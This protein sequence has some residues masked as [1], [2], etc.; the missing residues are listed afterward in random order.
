MATIFID[1]PKISKAQWSVVRKG[2][3]ITVKHLGL[4]TIPTHVTQPSDPNIE[5][6][7]G[8]SAPLATTFKTKVKGLAVWFTVAFVALAWLAGIEWPTAL[9]TAGAGTLA[10]FP[11]LNALTSLSGLAHLFER[12]AMGRDARALAEEHRQPLRTEELVVLFGYF[13]HRERVGRE[14]SRRWRLPPSLTAFVFGAAAHSMSNLRHMLG[15]PSPFALPPEDEAAL[16]SLD[17]RARVLARVLMSG[18]ARPVNFDP[19]P[20][21]VGDAARYLSEGRVRDAMESAFKSPDEVTDPFL[22][23]AALMG[24]LAGESVT[25]SENGVLYVYATGFENMRADRP[26]WS[27]L[28]GMLSKAAA[29][30]RVQVV[31]AGTLEGRAAVMKLPAAQKIPSKRMLIG[32][33]KIEAGRVNPNT[34]ETDNR[35]ISVTGSIQAVA[36]EEDVF[37]ESVKDA[38]SLK[39]LVQEISNQLR[40]IAVALASA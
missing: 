25:V 38:I 9:A 32:A 7:F 34:V 35:S 10:L 36:I 33:A 3:E 1:D 13:L 40:T 12:G 19:R 26:E 39:S 22:F 4:A 17:P 21:V 29:D 24:A 30:P 2:N 5:E 27:L 8:R 6:S 18:S 14:F 28:S 31:I 16:A 23:R 15:R 11:I 20:G 37:S